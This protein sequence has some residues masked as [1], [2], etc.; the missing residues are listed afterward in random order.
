M[1]FEIAVE[2]DRF[3]VFVRVLVYEFGVQLEGGIRH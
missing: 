3:K 1:S 2:A